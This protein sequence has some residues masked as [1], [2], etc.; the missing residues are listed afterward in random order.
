[1]TNSPFFSGFFSVRPLAAAALV[2]LLTQPMLEVQAQ[3]LKPS[4]SLRLAIPAAPASAAAGQ[5]QADFIVAVVNSEPITNNEVRTKLLRTEQ[6]IAQ[7]GAPMPPRNELVQQVLERLIN[8]KLQLQLARESGVRVDDNAVEAAVQTV[9]RQ[10]QISVEVLRSRLR[11]DGI[12]YSEFQSNLRDEL[13]VSRLRQREVESR[14]TVTEQDIDQFLRDQSGNTELSSL[15]LNLA[16]ILV[17]VPE[18]ATPEQVAVLQV[19][20]QQVMERARAGGDFVA[21]ANEF[22]DSPTRSSGGQMGLREADRYP[23]LFVEA[24]KGLP[25]GA[26]AGPVRSGAGFHIL[27]VIEKRQAGMPGVAITQTHARHILLRITPQLSEAAAVEKLAGFKKRI[28][29]GQADFAALARESSQ[30][31]SAKEGG[32][33]G[34]ANPGLFVPEFEQAMNGLAPNQISDPL[35]SRFG[36]HLLQVLERREAQLSS[37][38]QREIARNLLREKKQDEAYALWVQEIRGRAYVEYR[39]PPQ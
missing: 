33:L 35:V 8:D 17:A 10:N 30:D 37:R 12:A 31:G 16:Q 7:Q 6:Q 14:V 36:V 22:S 34:W 24:A 26:L 19:K 28:L 38:E 20:A 4:G 27:K 18:K 13:L 15:A 3:S 5:R 11:A 29:A 23:P 21:L 25:T 32:D 9:A 1:M 2:L 39:E